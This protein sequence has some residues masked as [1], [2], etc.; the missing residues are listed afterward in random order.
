MNDLKDYRE[1]EL[2]KFVVAH[3]LIFLL[4]HEFINFSNYETEEIFQTISSVTISGIIV[5]L[6]YIFTLLI[7]CTISSD[8]KNKLVN[9]IFWEM[10]G[11]T[12][13][14]DIKVKNKDI[15]FT[16]KQALEKYVDVYNEMPKEEKDRK[17]HENKC[18]YNIY[19]IHRKEAMILRS[20]RDYLLMRDMYI[21]T[22]AIFIMYLLSVFLLKQIVF[23]CPFFLYVLVMLIITNIATR[24][25]AKA[26]VYN[27]IS[28]DISK[29]NEGKE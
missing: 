27:V 5:S 24:V 15:R 26:F 11:Q 6:I 1:N 14:T 21:S 18:W 13:F 10:P 19:S 20:H 16:K 12:I 8:T 17:A 2:K 7:D 3:I 4:L 28:C 25:K 9:L 29:I 23:N 22:L